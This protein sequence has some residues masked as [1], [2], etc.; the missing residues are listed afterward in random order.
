MFFFDQFTEFWR[1][2]KPS[3]LFFA[4]VPHWLNIWAWGDPGHKRI[5]NQAS[6]TFLSQ[7]QYQEQIDKVG[8]P[9]TN[10][11]HYYNVDFDVEFAE[12]VENAKF[13]FALKAIKEQK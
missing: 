12:T 3:G 4:T 8:T 6:I 5:I 10:Y 11:R 2:L 13:V 7:K 1:I 9:M